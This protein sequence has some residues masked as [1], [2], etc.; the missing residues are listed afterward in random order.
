[1]PD[2]LPT[3][4]LAPA[5]PAPAN[6]PGVT[7]SP[8]NQAQLASLTKT[9]EIC[10]V[11][12]KPEY[13]PVLI[14]PLDPGQ[15]AAE[16][17]I[18]EAGINDLIEKCT[19]VRTFSG[20]AAT[21]TTGKVTMTGEEIAARDALLVIIRQ[22][23][24]RARQKYHTSNPAVLRDYG[25]GENLDASRAILEG[26]AQSIYDKTAD[27]KLP[28]ITEANREA[29]RLALQA[30]KEA[31]TSQ[32]GAQ[33]KAGQLRVSRD[34]LLKETVAGR[35]RIQFAAEAEFPFTDSANYPIRGEFQLPA[36]RAF[37]G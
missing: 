18:T 12:L 32:T 36:N 29:L 1:M 14:T 23:Q 30:Y 26:Y 4:N 31:Q 21:A 37:V 33:S 13:L 15:Q 5:N 34:E 10:R 8:L 2:T 28:K 20:Q 17:D 11:A 25:I 22:F 3:A 27:D 6:P 16:E 7:P 35:M 9:E 19:Q 24:A